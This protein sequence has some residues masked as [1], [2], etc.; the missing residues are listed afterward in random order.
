MTLNQFLLAQPLPG[1]DPLLL[2]SHLRL[3]SEKHLHHLYFP[4]ELRDFNHDKGN[5]VAAVM[6]SL[7]CM[8][9]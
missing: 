3:D 9:V 6:S 4:S 7:A 8:G 2:E 1:P 5:I